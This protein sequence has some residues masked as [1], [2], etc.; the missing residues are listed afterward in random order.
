MLRFADVRRRLLITAM[1]ASSLAHAAPPEP[2]GPHPRML[3]DRELR[4]QWKAMAKLP[5]GPIAGAI[6]LCEQARTT[7]DHDRAL[8]QG[9]EWARVLQACLVAW[10]ATDSK[11]DAATAVKFM[12]ALL[13]DLDRLG[14]GR[15]GDDAAKRDHGYALRNL[16]PWTAIAYDWLHGHPLLTRELQARA[17]QR[18]KVWLDWYKEKGYR[19]T[20]PGSNYHAG[21]LIAATTIAIAQAGE[22][23]P[24]G[25]ALWQHVADQMWGKEMAVALSQDGV[26]AGG[27]WPEGWQYGPLSV[28]EYSLG[29]RLMKGAGAGVQGVE[30]WL[31]SVLRHHVYSLSPS[32]GVYASGDTEFETATL[33]PHM[34]TLSAIAFGDA[35]P[36]DKRWARGELVRLKLVDRDWFLFGALAAVGE[37]PTLPPR[38]AWPTWYVSANTGTLYARTRWDDTGIWFVSECHATIKT[39]HRHPSA[40]NFALSRGRDDVIVDP[41]PYGSQSTLTSN[42]PAVASGHLPPDY[43]PSQGAWSE[44]TGYD[45]ITQRASG[46]VAA[47]CDYADQF[48]FQHRPSDIPA[49]V[50]DWVLL[51]SSDGR[52]AAL[53][54]IDR[55]TTGASDRGMHL[56]FRTPGKLAVG[57]E[58]GTAIVGG[59]MLAIT[60]VARSAPGTTALGESMAKDCYKLGGPKGQCD[61]A[62]FPVTDYRAQIPGP[63]PSAVHLISATGDKTPPAKA[64]RIKGTGWEGVRVSGVRDATVVWRTGEGGALDYTAPAGTHVIL[65]PPDVT[66]DVSAK[67]AGKGCA[68]SVRGGGKLP[69]RPLVINLDAQCNVALDREA[70][71]A[72]AIGTRAPRSKRSA[73]SPRSGC[74]G[75]EATPGSAFAMTIVVLA[76]LWRRRRAS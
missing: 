50:R 12:T 71:A 44:K 2:K 68:V 19:A 33:K 16:G 61:A 11:D 20:T 59:S 47:R 49:A 7:G 30:T 13:D 53:L 40:G 15:G 72:S 26:L 38:S 43:I 1:L 10:A 21:Y 31:S 45:F 18:W 52:D 58:T 69:A 46:V 8:Y 62:R 60:S 66:A 4:A 54:V 22:A 3:L 41:T 39:D 48:K 51:P 75:A 23:G 25:T 27:N 42:A 14:D 28:A 29:A 65:D 9:S 56:R 5:V 55:A 24:G 67:Q 64:E 32:D 36:Q 35:S 74:C 17:R 37:K 57:G 6:R 63:S 34:L 76:M 70:A 73:R